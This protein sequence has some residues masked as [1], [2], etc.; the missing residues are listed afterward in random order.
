MI[1]VQSL[2][3]AFLNTFIKQKISFRG[4]LL[5]IVYPICCGIDVHK[6]FLVACIASTN[7]QG[8]TT[9]VSKSFSTFIGDLRKC[10]A[11]LASH[12]C[13]DVRIESTPKY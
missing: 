10:S 11:W 12:N 2:K 7:T 3:I 8:A 9:Y 1:M 5:K 6:S 13:K 4:S